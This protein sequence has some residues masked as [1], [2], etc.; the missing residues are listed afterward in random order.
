MS[1]DGESMMENDIRVPE[2]V[3]RHD[4]EEVED[5]CPRALKL[6]EL[7]NNDPDPLFNKCG[8]EE[9]RNKKI[10]KGKYPALKK[11]KGWG[12]AEFLTLRTETN[13]SP[14][15][16]IKINNKGSKPIEMGD[17]RINQIYKKDKINIGY[18]KQNGWHTREKNIFLFAPK[19]VSADEIFRQIKTS[20]K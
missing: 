16:V 1:E 18:L 17:I 7:F 20:V 9:I 10:E 19:N 5:E 2:P 8:N 6:V 15:F 4:L 12:R 11:E 14:S 13:D 3:S